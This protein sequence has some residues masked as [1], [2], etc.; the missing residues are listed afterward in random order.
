[1]D[2]FI[3]LEIQEIAK[4]ARII[5]SSNWKNVKFEMMSFKYLSVDTY[6]ISVT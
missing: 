4:C 2:V 6:I 5:L 1:M 3:F